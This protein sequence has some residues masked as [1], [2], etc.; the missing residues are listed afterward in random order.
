MTL[1]DVLLEQARDAASD[2]E[3]AAR[4]AAI[5]YRGLEEVIGPPLAALARFLLWAALPEEGE[6]WRCEHGHVYRVDEACV[7]ADGAADV[8]V[9]PGEWQGEPAPCRCPYTRWHTS[10]FLPAWTPVPR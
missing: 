6:H 8:R 3:A 1:L 4:L 2:A 5:A 10:A 9:R 7:H